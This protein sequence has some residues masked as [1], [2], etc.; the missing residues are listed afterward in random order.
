MEHWKKRLRWFG[1]R[2]EDKR[3]QF[4]RTTCLQM[5]TAGLTGENGDI[6]IH[7]KQYENPLK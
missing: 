5:G 3:H 1:N 6:E 4:L 7:Q 2:L